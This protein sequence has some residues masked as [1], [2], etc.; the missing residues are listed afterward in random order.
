MFIIN[1]FPKRKH[2]EAIST[3]SYSFSNVKLVDVVVHSI[4]LFYKG[5]SYD[6]SKLAQFN[7]AQSRINIH[8]RPEDFLPI[9]PS[10]FHFRVEYSLKGSDA[11]STYAEHIKFIPRMFKSIRDIKPKGTGGYTQYRSVDKE[12]AEQRLVQMIKDALT[13]ST[14]VWRD[15]G[16]DSKIEMALIIR[17]DTF[18]LSKE[19]FDKYIAKEIS[20]RMLDT[21]AK[22]EYIKIYAK[23]NRTTKI[24]MLTD[25][26]ERQ[27]AVRALSFTDKFVVRLKELGIEID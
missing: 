14:N 17:G 15:Y 8:F 20:K 4:A 2:I 26:K 1:N 22:L 16:Y 9:K 19:Y 21:L 23:N 27:V 6:L 25:N 3:L 18:Y 7:Y 12:E 10:V 24:K 13:Q 5:L 11:I